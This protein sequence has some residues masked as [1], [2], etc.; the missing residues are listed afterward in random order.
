MVKYLLLD[1]LIYLVTFFLDLTHIHNFGVS[2]KLNSHNIKVN[3]LKRPKK[4]LQ[5]VESDWSSA[6]YFFSIVALS[7]EAEIHLKSY[8][9]E[10]LQ[11]DAVLKSI[12]KDL[13]VNSR[14]V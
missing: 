14:F 6:S 11:G 5:L 9:P 1:L 2:F 12:Y 7:E 3:Y 10:S 8:K 13:G 4:S